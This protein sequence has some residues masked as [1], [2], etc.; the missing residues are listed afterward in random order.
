LTAVARPTGDTRPGRLLS[1]DDV[2]RLFAD[3]VAVNNNDAYL[4]RYDKFDFGSRFG[5]LVDR[6]EFPRLI[7]VLEFER[8]LTEHSIAADSVLM[9]N[10]GEGGDPELA[11][12]DHH[13]VDRADY[14]Q[15]P[16]RFDLHSP[17]FDRSDYDFALLSQTLEHLYDPALAVAQ[18]YSAGVRADGQPPASAAAPFHNWLH[19]NRLGLPL[20]ACGL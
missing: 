10:G 3:K 1:G 18:L 8:I 15:D 6:V 9:L 7:T 14:D 13:Q 5:A 20:C 4:G 2:E 16:A 11:Y 17:Q 19:A 12:L